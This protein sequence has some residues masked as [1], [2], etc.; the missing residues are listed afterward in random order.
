M[1][2]MNQSPGI[3]RDQNVSAATI[4]QFYILIIIF[5]LHRAPHVENYNL[6]NLFSFNLAKLLV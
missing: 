5:R 6:K 3:V 4:T 2:E 1:Q